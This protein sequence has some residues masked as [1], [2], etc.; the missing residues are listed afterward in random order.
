MLQLKRVVALYES[1]T[2][3]TE[4]A[5]ARF[6]LFEIRSP[7][8]RR[9]ALRAQKCSSQRAVALRVAPQP[10]TEPH[11]NPPPSKYNTTQ[12]FSQPGNAGCACERD[13]TTGWWRGLLRRGLSHAVVSIELSVAAERRPPAH[14]ARAARALIRPTLLE[15]H[16]RRRHISS[17]CPALL[18]NGRKA[19]GL[20]R[21][22]DDDG[23]RRTCQVALTAPISAPTPKDAMVDETTLLRHPC[24]ARSW[25]GGES[26]T[27]IW[28]ASAFTS[29]KSGLCLH[30]TPGGDRRRGRSAVRSLT[31]EGRHGSSSVRRREQSNLSATNH[32]TL[33]VSP[34]RRRTSSSPLTIYNPV[35]TT[36]YKQL[37]LRFFA[38]CPN[39]KKRDTFQR[40]V[41]A[42]KFSGHAGAV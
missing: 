34:R 17:T 38:D 42:I 33:R 26:S 2:A 16:Q 31:T 4:P 3:S 40:N 24:S 39:K 5:R 29:L 32:H 25:A 12:I 41:L 1:A 28:T 36:A 18:F 6:A 8:R 19:R 7:P 20:E 15:P 22:L 10:A 21:G 11:L 9:R 27:L 14:N 35:E 13:G 30:Y 37:P 23:A